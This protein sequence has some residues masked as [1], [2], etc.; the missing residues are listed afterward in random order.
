M[1]IAIR[2]ARPDDGP[3]LHAIHAVATMSS[4]GRRLPWLEP[5][6]QDP[7]TP[8][9]V[10]EWTIVAHDAGDVLGYAAVTAAHLENLYVDPAAQRRGVGAAL[11][12]EVE[13]RVRARYE[14]ITLRC[15]LA[16][17]DARRLYERNGYL[18][19]ETQR[20]VLHGK[21]LDAWLMAK[22]LR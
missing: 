3:R 20:I 1:S 13:A 22:P 8:L 7:A 9:E 12:A 16:N 14:A 17:P 11:L 19:R 10:V 4:Y 5:I 21:P 2:D 15:L 6:L 18:V